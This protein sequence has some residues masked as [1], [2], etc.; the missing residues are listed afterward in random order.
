MPIHHINI[1]IYKAAY[2]DVR[3]FPLRLLLHVGSLKAQKFSNL[4]E[5]ARRPRFFLL[6]MKEDNN[7]R[8]KHA[9]MKK[10]RE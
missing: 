2:S 4:Y 9:N 5:N 7:A 8:C 3:H 1:Y 10:L 6:K